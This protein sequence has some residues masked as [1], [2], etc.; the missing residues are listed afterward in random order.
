MAYCAL[1]IPVLA[2]LS[3]GARWPHA[4]AEFYAT[5]AQV[6]VTLVIAIAVE[7]VTDRDQRPSPYGLAVPLSLFFVGWIG[8]LASIRGLAGS[9]SGNSLIAGCSAA[10]LTAMGL[11]TSLALFERI[12]R[13]RA[14]SSP[15][16]AFAVM[17]SY[18][19]AVLLVF[20]FL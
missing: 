8:L 4:G 2:G 7:V 20:M 1:P 17:A 11:L 15:Y 13:G 18:L 12:E 16:A 19:V 5:V 9:S 3:V 10:G 14:E 6:I